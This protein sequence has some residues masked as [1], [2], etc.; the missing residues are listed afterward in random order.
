MSILA[1]QSSPKLLALLQGSAVAAAK[2]CTG[3]NND[4]ECGVKWYT[5]K[6]DGTSGMEQD[7]SATSLF[8]ANLVAFEKQ[9][10]GTQSSAVNA[11]A[12]GTS[13]G[14]ANGTSTSSGTGTGS[15]AATTTGANAASVLVGGPFAVVA[16][17][18]AGIIAIF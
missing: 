12:A 4:T 5:G 6:W 1:P 10:P 8:T 17:I 14:S 18:M 11:T 13:T 9:A 16:G 3:G 7:L 2:S 15:A